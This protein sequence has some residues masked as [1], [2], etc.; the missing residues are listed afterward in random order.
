MIFFKG[1]L[2]GFLM[3][4]P[5]GP[6]GV[7][8][9]ERSL[10]KGAFSGMLTGLGSATVDIFYSSVAAFS[11]TLISSFIADHDIAIRLVGGF[12][13]LGIGLD[14]L[15]SKGKER[16]RPAF[17]N[18][19]KINGHARDYSTGL[20]LTLLNPT[21]IVTFSIFFALTGFDAASVRAIVPPILLVLGVALGSLLWFTTV[22]YGI[23]YVHTTMKIISLEMV[24]K[25]AGVLTI[26]FALIILSG[27][28]K[29]L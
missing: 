21:T 15:I 26:I 29:A 20:L 4:V 27:L 9:I 19:I 17:L 14:Y 10:R 5:I 18:R 8:C 1:I 2:L 16:R 11:L 23:T 3:A 25:F 28:G 7:L 24:R 12:I 13:I 6:V 22:S